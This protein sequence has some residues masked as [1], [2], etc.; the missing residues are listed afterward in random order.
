[1]KKWIIRTFGLKGSWVWAKKQMLKGG[2]VRCKHWTGALRFRID[3]PENTLLQAS[4]HRGNLRNDKEEWETSNHHLNF[5]NFTDYEL[6]E[7]EETNNA[8]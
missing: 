3:S 5:E 6:I 1:M 2:A 7:T 8:N 4:F